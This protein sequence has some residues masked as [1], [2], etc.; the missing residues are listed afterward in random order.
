M[1]VCV[2][3][4]SLKSVSQNSRHQFRSCFL[5]QLIWFVLFRELLIISSSSCLSRSMHKLK[6]TFESIH[7]LQ[8]RGMSIMLQ[9][10]SIRLT[11]T[12]IFSKLV[13]TQVCSKRSHSSD[14]NSIWTTLL[15]L[16]LRKLW[17]ITIRLSYQWTIQTMVNNMQ[18]W[19]MLFSLKTVMVILTELV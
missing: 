4:D 15:P 19:A 14:V 11:G 17:R 18:W 6:L 16:S 2:H 9:K 1:K 12:I 10:C 13:W 7:V 8:R 3:K 5:W